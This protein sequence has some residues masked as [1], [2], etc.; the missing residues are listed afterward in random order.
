MNN[1][2]LH[3]S[4]R[5]KSQQNNKPATK[6]QVFRTDAMFV[7]IFL[8]NYDWLHSHKHTRQGYREAT[9]FQTDLILIMGQVT[10]CSEFYR[11]QKEVLCPHHKPWDHQK[12][13]F[14][15]K[16]K[17]PWLQV[18]A[19]NPIHPNTTVGS[20]SAWGVGRGRI[21]DSDGA[22]TPDGEV[23]STGILSN[24]HWYWIAARRLVTYIRVK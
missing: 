22:W 4:R 19:W 21:P 14:I 3:W 11:N 12:Y 17:E 6:A 24:R 2:S 16:S 10:Y 20:E 5:S 1:C 8:P 18:Q 7:N 13:E 23:C 9:S 15:Y